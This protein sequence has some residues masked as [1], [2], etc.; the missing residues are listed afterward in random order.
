M[1][2]SDAYREWYDPSMREILRARLFR[3]TQT[4]WTTSPAVDDADWGERAADRNVTKR[5]DVGGGDVKW[6][7]NAES[8]FLRAK[9]A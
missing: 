3:T 7:E 2:H 9:T 4:F 5:Y 8:F 6:L 1:L